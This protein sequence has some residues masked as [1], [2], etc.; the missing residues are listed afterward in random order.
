VPLELAFNLFAIACF[1]VLRWRRLL[2]GQHFHL[3]LIGYGFFRF[4]NEWLRATPRWSGE[5]SGYHLA[6]LGVA[7]FGMICF[8]RRARAQA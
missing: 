6:A 1:A 7:G 4:G 8:M 3:Y 5:F 2:T